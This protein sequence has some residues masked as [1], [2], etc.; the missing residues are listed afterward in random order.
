MIDDVTSVPRSL[1]R[2]AAAVLPADYT[3]TLE[4]TPPAVPDEDRPLA[5][6]LPTSEVTTL[7][8]RRSIP[9]GDVQRQQSFALTVYP[10]VKAGANLLT[11]K[12]T[13][14]EARRLTALLEDAV[15]IGTTEG[16]AGFSYPMTVPLWDYTGVPETGPDRAGPLQP[17]SAAEVADHTVRPLADPDDPRRRTVVLSLRLTWWAAGRDRLLPAPYPINTGGVEPGWTEEP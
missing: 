2:W 11:V 13:G 7:F 6:V 15:V 1:K 5:N 14:A 3:V 16:E 12:E 4:E 10:A 8:A 17:A 9:Q